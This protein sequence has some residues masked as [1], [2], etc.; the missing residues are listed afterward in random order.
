M[1]RAE[2]ESGAAMVVAITVAAAVEGLAMVVDG[3]ID[4]RGE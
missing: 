2:E 3:L 1:A 4:W